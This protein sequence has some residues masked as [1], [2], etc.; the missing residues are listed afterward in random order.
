MG[1][2]LTHAES[3]SPFFK[4]FSDKH[5]RWSFQV[6]SG[7][8]EWTYQDQDNVIILQSYSCRGVKRLWSFKSRKYYPFSRHLCPIFTRKSTP[9]VNNFIETD[10]Y[11]S[12]YCVDISGVAISGWLPLVTLATG[13]VCRTNPP[14]THFCMMQ[15]FESDV[16]LSIHA[17]GYGTYVP[18]LGICCGWLSLS[19]FST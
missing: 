1:F 5:I 19:I 4:D 3:D 7:T 8:S 17:N 10:G 13:F 18:I 6:G 2:S 15:I 16:L 9:F 14:S 12:T 11:T